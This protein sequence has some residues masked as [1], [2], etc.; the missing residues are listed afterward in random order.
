MFELLSK[1]QAITIYYL[2]VFHIFSLDLIENYF[3]ILLYLLLHINV[4]FKELA[5]QQ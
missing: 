5:G 1:L 3:Y 2:N 4:Q